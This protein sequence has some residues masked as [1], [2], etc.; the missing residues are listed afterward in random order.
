MDKAKAGTVFTSEQLAWL[1]LMRDQ[2]AT[3]ITIE[4]DDLDLAL[5]STWRI[6]KSSRNVWRATPE[7]PR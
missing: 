2:I 4:R 5:Q 3:S 7:T 1:N 6:R